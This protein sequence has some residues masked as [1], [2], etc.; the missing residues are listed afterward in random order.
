MR[1]AGGTA[2]FSWVAD[3]SSCLVVM[4]TTGRYFF[5]HLGR[6]PFGEGDDASYGEGLGTLLFFGSS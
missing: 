4:A 5:R 1:G 6:V 3:A 2:L